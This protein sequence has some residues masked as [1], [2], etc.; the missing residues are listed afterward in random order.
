MIPKFAD[1]VSI[2]AFVRCLNSGQSLDQVA[3]SSK[4]SKQQ[5]LGKLKAAGYRRAPNG[6]WIAMG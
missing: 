3:A 6:T 5:I 1:I 4:M 2:I